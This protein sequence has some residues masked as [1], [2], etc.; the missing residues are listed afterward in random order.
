MWRRV[1]EPS[2]PETLLL[3]LA[4]VSSVVGSSWFALSIDA[5]WRQLRGTALRSRGS[6]IVLR[7]AGS[8]AVLAS[9]A[10]CLHADHG[11][12]VS[13]TFVMLLVAGALIVAFT[14]AWRPRWLAPL[15][16]FVR[17]T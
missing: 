8:I 6:V 10:L 12:M 14:L 5:H 4:L 7:V 16:A 13:L 9:L 2:V 11:S 15:V 17:P 1:R 3:L